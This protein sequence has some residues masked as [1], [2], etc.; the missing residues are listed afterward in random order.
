MKTSILSFLFCF[1]LAKSNAQT[2]TWTFEKSHCKI[3]FSIAHFGISETEG[4]F[5][6]FDGNITTSKS[7]FSDAKFTMTIDVNS[8]DTDDSKR[9][10]HLKSADFFDAT[11]Y[12][13]I[14]F[15]SQSFKKTGN[16]KYQLTGSLTMHGVTKKITLNAVYGGTVLKDPFGNTKAGFKF[17]G[18]INRKD[19]GL[20]WNK[21]MDAGGVAVGN[22]VT[23]TCNVEFLKSK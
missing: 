17:T 9:D 2:P 18:K 3:G 5:R 15:V 19:W 23:I 22:E 14:T 20:T 4:Q 21:T 8:I 11:Q 12:P 13:T 7:D 16:N 10:E 6:K 1:A